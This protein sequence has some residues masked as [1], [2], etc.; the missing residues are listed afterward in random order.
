MRQMNITSGGEG[1]LLIVN[2][3]SFK[4]T[5]EVAREKGTNRAQFFRGEVDKYTWVDLGSSCLPS[6]IQ[7]AYLWGQIERIE[8]T[9]DYRKKLWKLYLDTL[10]PLAKKGHFSL[11]STPSGCEQNGHIFYI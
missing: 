2:D 1:G 5:A 9:M 6:E 3:E 10:T 8:D 7:A 4:A 11:P